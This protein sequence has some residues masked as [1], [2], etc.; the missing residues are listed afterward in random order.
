MSAWRSYACGLM[1]SRQDFAS[2]WTLTSWVLGWFLR[3]GTNAV[4]WVLMGA[5]LQDPQKLQF[6]ALG[7]ALLAG[8]TG[9]AWTIPS[10]TWDRLD[11]TY[12]LV[13]I[14]PGSLFAVTA[15][16][17]TAWFLSGIV[18]SALMFALFGWLFGV[19]L[20]AASLPVLGVVILSVCASSFGF[21]LVLG[22]VA[23][24]WRQARNII[25]NLA[26]TAL[27]A[28]CGASVTMEFWPPAVRVLAELLPL[29][30][31][32][33]SLRLL[34]EGAPAAAVGSAILCEILVGAGWFAVALLTV[35]RLAEGGRRDGSIE[36]T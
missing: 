14:A 33:S 8:P 5:L 19:S 24:R 25:Q 31:G 13:V 35:R 23:T 18:T 32:L 21:C 34:Q 26:L 27:M 3:V 12:P 6:I 30:H 22:A 36:L 9:V 10:S 28:F 11:G 15:G 20:P 16:R 17:T 7:Q 1:V 4:L 29:T 2:H